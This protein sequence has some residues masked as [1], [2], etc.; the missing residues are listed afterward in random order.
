MS[1]QLKYIS[2]VVD[3]YKKKLGIENYIIEI[4]L[5]DD[6]HIMSAR[7][8]K[9]IQ[10]KT[11][12]WGE[13]TSEDYQGKEFTITI[14]KSLPKKRIKEIVCHELIHALF[15]DCIEQVESII[16][17]SGFPQDKQ[18]KYLQTVWDKEH[19]VIDKLMEIIL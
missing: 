1:A 7:H 4:L 13:T 12:N 8:S 2:N 16:K 10:N 19:I 17:L 9:S 18:D 3:K 14:N 15:W 11:E 5:C 6:K